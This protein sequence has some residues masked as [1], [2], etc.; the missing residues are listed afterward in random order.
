MIFRPLIAAAGLALLSGCATMNEG[1]CRAADWYQIGLRDGRNGEPANRLASHAEACSEYGVR[2]QEQRYAQGHKEGL[3]EYCRVE[4]AFETGLKGQRYQGVC[5]SDVDSAFRRYNDAAYE[6]HRLRNEIN[7]TQSEVDGKE[8]RLREK[9][10][11]ERKRAD[12]RQEIHDLDRKLY[13]LRDDLRLREREL[14][15]LMDKAYAGRRG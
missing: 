9:K 15:R 2:P 4:N 11:S 3:R 6:V 12:L 10:T 8:D 7:T 5:P 13:R 1:E 14:D